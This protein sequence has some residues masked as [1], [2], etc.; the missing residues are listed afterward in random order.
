MYHIYCDENR[1]EMIGQDRPVDRYSV[2][3]GVWIDKSNIRKIKKIYK[4]YELSII[5]LVKL[6]GKMYPLLKLSSI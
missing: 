1:P 3:G 5:Y 4:D 2:L 6:N